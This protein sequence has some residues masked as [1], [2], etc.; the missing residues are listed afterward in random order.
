MEFL[1][2][3]T[4]FSS[5]DRFDPTIAEDKDPW[6][7]VPN[8]AVEVMSKTNTV[9]EI[10]EKMEDYFAAGVESVWVVSNRVRRVTVYTS[11]KNPVVYEGDESIDAAPVLPGL[12]IPLE[13]IFA[14]LGK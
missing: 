8:L 7:F 2:V 5:P 3:R 1:D 11:M 14:V 10:E 6:E 4:C 12:L 9:N 13:K